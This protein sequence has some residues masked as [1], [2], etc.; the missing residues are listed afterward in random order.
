MIFRLSQ[1][2]QNIPEDEPMLFIHS[3]F[4]LSYFAHGIISLCAS[5]ACQGTQGARG[6]SGMPAQPQ[7]ICSSR[8][9]KGGRTIGQEKAIVAT[10]TFSLGPATWGFP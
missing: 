1:V 6:E 9:K 4:I 7:R 8:G 10:E 5:P 3:A 2:S